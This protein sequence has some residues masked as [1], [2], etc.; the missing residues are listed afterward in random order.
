MMGF[1]CGILGSC[2]LCCMPSQ[3]MEELI[4]KIRQKDTNKE[5]FR[6][7]LEKIGELLA[8]QVLENLDKT[9]VEVETLL[10]CKAHHMLVHQN[11]VLIT[12]LRAGLPLNSGVMKVFPESDVGFIAM[13]RDE[14]TLKSRTSYIACPDITDKIVILTDT[15]LATGG[16]LVDAIKILE[17]KKPSQIYVLCAIASQ[18][19]IDRIKSQFTE[20]KVFAACIDPTLNDKGFIVPGLGDAGDRSFGKKHEEN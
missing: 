8:Y 15:M 3:M 9:D 10:G 11:P 7:H 12:I 16:S 20:I 17:K 14:S 4:Y 2:V 19:G 6:H 5:M 13:S 1:L 18:V